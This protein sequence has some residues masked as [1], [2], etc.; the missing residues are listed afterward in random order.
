VAN[1]SL[2][3][4]VALLPPLL[5]PTLYIRATSFPLVFTQFYLSQFSTNK[6]LVKNQLETLGLI[7]ARLFPHFDFIS[8]R[9]SQPARFNSLKDSPLTRLVL[10][11]RPILT[12]GASSVD[13]ETSTREHPWIK[14]LPQE[15]HK[16]VLQ[17][18]TAHSD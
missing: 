17:E 6:L 18:N 3:I 5:P 1:I 9:L 7:R 10:R 14:Q 15:K 16:G 4:S 12:F 13:K 11:R 8:Q 2:R